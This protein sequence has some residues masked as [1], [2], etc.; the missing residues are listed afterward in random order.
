MVIYHHI[1]VKINTYMTKLEQIVK[2]RNISFYSIGVATGK[3]PTFITKRIRGESS[4]EFPLLI[5]IINVIN[6]KSDSP[7]TLEDL[8]YNVL[9]VV[10]K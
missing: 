5:K 2:E 10:V 3:Q 8:D 7:I 4:M 6:E 9:Q 1:K